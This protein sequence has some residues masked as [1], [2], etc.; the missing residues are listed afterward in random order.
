MSAQNARPFFSRRVGLSPSGSPIDINA[1]AKLGGRIGDWNV[2]S[3]FISQG[4]DD[5]IGLEAQNIFVGRAALNVLSESQVGVI[6]TSGDPQSNTDNNLLGVDFSLSKF[7]AAGRPCCQ[8]A[9]F[10][11]ENRY[12]REKRRRCL[13]GLWYERP[14]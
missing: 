5:A 14:Q 2:G 11:P 7:A 6:A 10:L 1:G 4:E 3:L 12:G 13:V 8:G 9:F